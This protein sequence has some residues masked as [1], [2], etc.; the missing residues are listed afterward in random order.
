MEV[1]R[2]WTDLNI[3]REIF[4]E[5]VGCNRTYFSQVIKTH[6]GMSYT[7]FMNSRRVHEAVK[8]LGEPVEVSSFATLSRDLGFLSE[9]TFYAAFRQIMGM[10]PATY[11]K[12][13]L[14]DSSET[15]D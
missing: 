15:K 5:L 14:E 10:T 7:R 8:I 2:V 3:T 6:T 1:N 11:R 13:A 9:S 4:A 12:I